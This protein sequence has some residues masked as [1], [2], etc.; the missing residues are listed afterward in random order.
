M[1]VNDDLYVI[2]V[3]FAGPLGTMV[4]NLSLIVDP[5]H[6]LTLVDTSMPGHIDAVEAALAADGFALKDVKQIV[7]TH[8][9]IDHIG[10][11]TDLKQRTGATVIAHAVEAPYIEGKA[12]LAKY[13]S[14]ERL[15][16][17][18]GMK[19]MY[20]RIGFATADRLVQDGELLDVAGGVRILHTPGHTPGHISLYLERSRALIS[21]DAL[22]SEN[23][24]L[25][26]PLPRATPD[27]PTAIQSVQKLA[28][29]PEL[30]AIV[31]YHG[32]LV[33]DDPLG[34]LR[35]VAEKLATS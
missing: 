32:G 13:P 9:D 29:L 17:N 21:G 1:R 25:D 27:F 30:T 10:S 3:E 18:P 4:L 20:D 22:V 11:L 26:G 14:Q 16:Q 24:Q 2:P 28:A 6:G 5:E 12:P 7:V 34:Q 23:A 33:S 19:E 31:T 15:D 8:Q 35:Q